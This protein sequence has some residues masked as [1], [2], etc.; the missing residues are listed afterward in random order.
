MSLDVK[1][2]QM[3]RGGQMPP[4][5][6][7]LRTI[8]AAERFALLRTEASASADPVSR[9]R[10]RLGGM[11]VTAGLRL[12]ADAGCDRNGPGTVVGDSVG[13]IGRAR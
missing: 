13:V 3:E 4:T 2:L 9:V 6:T 11:L 1:I 12:A 8:L 10:R 5:D 7:Q